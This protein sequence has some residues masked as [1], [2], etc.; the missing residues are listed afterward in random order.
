MTQVSCKNNFFITY[1]LLI[2]AF[3]IKNELDNIMKDLFFENFSAFRV[4]FV[5]NNQLQH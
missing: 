1:F 2:I 5:N 4:L 3:K